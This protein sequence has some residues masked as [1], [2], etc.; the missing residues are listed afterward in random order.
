MSRLTRILLI[1]GAT[2]LGLFLVIQLI[3]FG[4]DHS[5]P[6]VAQEPNWDSPETRAIAQRACYDCHSNETVWPWYAN[7]APVSWLIVRDTLEGREHLNFSEWGRGEGEEAEELVEVVRSGE[8][9]PAQYVVMH[10]E[11]K[12]SADEQQALIQGLS[13]IGGQGETGRSGNEAS[14]HDRDED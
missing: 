12:L 4:R 2:L 14:E 5:N 3:P 6:A 7:V 1:G 11:A 9:P 8:M 13:R 10:P